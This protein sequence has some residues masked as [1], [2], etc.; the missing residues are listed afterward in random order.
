MDLTVS[1]TEQGND[2]FFWDQIN[3]IRLLAVGSSYD[4]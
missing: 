4:H 1:T 3:L 2:L